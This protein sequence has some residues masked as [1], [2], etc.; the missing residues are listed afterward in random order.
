MRASTG[1]GRRRLWTAARPGSRCGRPVRCEQ[2]GSTSTTAMLYLTVPLSNGAFGPIV[3]KTAGGMSTAFSLGL[4]GITG[5]ALSGTPADAGRRRPM[6]GQAVT[7]TGS[8]PVDVERY[9]AAL[10]GQRGAQRDGAAQPD[11]RRRAT[12]RARRWWCRDMPTGRSAC[13]CWVSSAQPLLQV[14]PTLTGY[15]V[16]GTTLQLFGSGLVEGNNASYQL[17]GGATVTRHGEHA[18]PD[19]FFRRVRQRRGS[20]IGEPVHGLGR[21]TVTTAGG[22]SAPLAVNELRPG[23]GLDLARRGASMRST[24]A[25]VGGGRSAQPGQDRPHRCGKRGRCRAASLLTSCRVR[26]DRLSTWRAAG[27]ASA[28]TLERRRRCLRAACCCSTGQTNPDRVTA[29]N[30]S[31]GSGDRHADAGGELRPDRRACTT[32]RAATCS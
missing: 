31:D 29:I 17:A 19:V 13:R 11:V 28:M 3:V 6:P 7:L 27:V 23:L 12:G 4:T 25:A 30:A 22:T 20:N 9:A 15:N 24:G 16:A 14:V 1:L 26:L 5:V 18:G 21:V 8:G 2:R 10:C 32:R